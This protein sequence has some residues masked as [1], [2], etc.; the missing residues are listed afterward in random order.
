M[1]RLDERAKDG[2]LTPEFL[3]DTLEIKGHIEDSGL[4]HDDESD[5]Q[6]LQH[7]IL[8][9][10]IAQQKP[11]ERDSADSGALLHDLSE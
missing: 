9:E 3:R 11:N 2:E 1:E 10:D 6:Y 4:F 8:L 7:L 5:S